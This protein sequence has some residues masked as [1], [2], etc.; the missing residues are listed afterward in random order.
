VELGIDPNLLPGT[1]E[2]A[3]A[4]TLLIRA[5]QIVP[6]DINPI[7]RKLT[8]RLLA[9]MEKELRAWWAT[10]LFV[11]CLMRTFLPPD[12]ADGPGVLRLLGFDELTCAALD[13]GIMATTVGYV[14]RDWGHR[15]VDQ[16]M[17]KNDPKETLVD[18]PWNLVAE[19]W[20]R[21]STPS[22]NIQTGGLQNAY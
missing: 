10:P 17:A 6:R 2:E 14:V 20:R 11:S 21:S 18:L 3:E 8:Q 22:V 7:G 9:M 19:W 1:F 13:A 4:L 15:L 16:V 12:V 5:R